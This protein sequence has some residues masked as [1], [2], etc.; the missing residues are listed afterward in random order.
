MYTVEEIKDE[1]SKQTME[2]SI[3]KP[4]I[5]GIL[6]NFERRKWGF[7]FQDD[8]NEISVSRYISAHILSATVERNSA[9]HGQ[10]E[11]QTRTGVQEPSKWH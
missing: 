5:Q 2:R 10:G 11:T 3:R 1:D 9:G 4:M 6:D 8:H 7:L